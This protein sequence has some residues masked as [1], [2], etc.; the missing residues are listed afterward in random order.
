V[1]PSPDESAV[2]RSIGGLFGLAFRVV[3]ERA[4]LYL[5]L[6]LGAFAAGAI[7]EWVLPVVPSDTP[8]GQFK[9]FVGIFT[10]IFADALV[11]A[12]VALGVGTKAGGE[13]APSSTLVSGA[14]Q[15]WLTVIFVSLMAQMIVIL[16]VP[17]SGLLPSRDVAVVVVVA[18][19]A[20]ATWLL[21]S[22]LGLA[23]PIAT[24]S[25]DRP[26]MAIVMSFGRAFALA[27]RRENALRLCVLA[28]VT[29]LPI[30][31]ETI[32]LRVML[33][34]HVPRAIFWAN[35]PLDVLTIVPVT[36]L[37]TAFALDFA[38]RAGRLE[39]PKS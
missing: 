37:Q 13:T 11:I 30:V 26:A 31:L 21:W 9:E 33:D 12:A 20:P 24:L 1:N 2:P 38:R 4:P 27:L 10:S 32:A 36:A 15:R 17:F 8:R 5:L 14:I 23:A 16:T 22:V 29:G 19:M 3:A 18:C 6:A 28:A 34:H 7:A 25:L 39:P 35:V